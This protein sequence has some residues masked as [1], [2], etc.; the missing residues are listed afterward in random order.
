TFR[1]SPEDAHALAR[2][3]FRNVASIDIDRPRSRVP[4]TISLLHDKDVVSSVRVVANDR[5][6]L[7]PATK[8]TLEAEDDDRIVL[9]TAS[10]SVTII[11]PIYGDFEATRAC[12]KSL[13][14]AIADDPRSRA[15]LVNDASPDDKIKSYLAK[16]SKLPNFV[17][18]TNATNRGFVG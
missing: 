11:I 3:K 6:S 12:L 8:P 10:D 17:V 7:G 15:I 16:F 18:L 14:S 4:H 9:Q 5:T 1:I 2:S 13:K